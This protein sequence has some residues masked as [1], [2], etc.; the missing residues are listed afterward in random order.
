MRNDREGIA[1]AVE[2]AAGEERFRRLFGGNEAEAEPEV[3]RSRPVLNAAAHVYAT[4]YEG[5]FARL[6]SPAAARLEARAAVDDFFA[7]VLAFDGPA[8]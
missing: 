7:S 6:H 5:A 8:G 2:R 4:V 3:D 1:G